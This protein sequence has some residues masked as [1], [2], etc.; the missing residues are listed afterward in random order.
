MTTPRKRQSGQSTVEFIL[1][2]ILLMGFVTFYT[3]FAYFLGYA[4]LVQYAT[5]MSARAYQSAA[6]T[7]DE[8]VAAAE[9]VIVAL[10][11]KSQG[12]RNTERFGIAKAETGGSPKG[13]RIGADTA[14]FVATDENFSWLQ[15]VRYSFRGQLFV[16]LFGTKPTAASAASGALPGEVMLTSE[17]WLGREPTDEE[18]SQ[19]LA[20]RSSGGI[21]L[22]E[23][24]NGC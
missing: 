23:P 5:F 20:T 9:S 15:G 6:A 16:N 3:R 11:K 14:N 12:Q 17:S 10:L 4:N 1:T 13:A 2:I 21:K 22:E 8:Q 18:C 7:Q 19:E 24:D